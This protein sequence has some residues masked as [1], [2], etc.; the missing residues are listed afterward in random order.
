MYLL[1]T[2]IPQFAIAEIATRAAIAL[3]VF[4]FGIN[5]LNLYSEVHA[6][7]LITASTLIWLINLFIPSVIGLFVLPDIKLF[8][9]NRK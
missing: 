2:I 4:D 5:E 8:S 3:I 7:V 9:K 1:I 6:T